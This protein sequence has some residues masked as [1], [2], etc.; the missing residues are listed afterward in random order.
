MRRRGLETGPLE[1]LR[2]TAPRPL[3]PAAV[4]PLATALVAV[5][6]VLTVFLGVSFA[7]QRRAGWLDTSVDTRVRALLGGHPVLQNRMSGLGDRRPMIA[8]TGALLLACLATR[9][10]RGAVLVAAAVP[11]AEWLTER[12]KPLIGRTLLGDYSLPSGH[13]TGVFAV[14]VAFAVLLADPPRPRMPVALRVLVALAALLVAGAVAAALVGMHAH[15]A[16]DT[17]AGAAVATAVVLATALIL[18][19]VGPLRG[20]GSVSGGRAGGWMSGRVQRAGQAEDTT[21]ADVSGR[22]T[23]A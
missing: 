12:L 23:P 16:T 7:H 6:V 17:V 2:R 3:L 21:S 20:P 11:V 4:R 18:D 15:Y 8:M 22:G 9:R 13:T 19:R 1:R 10:V 5:C 14:A